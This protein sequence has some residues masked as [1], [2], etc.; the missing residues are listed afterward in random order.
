MPRVRV[1]LLAALLLVA[2]CTRPGE[3]PATTTK[4]GIEVVEPPADG[5]GPAPC[6]SRAAQRVAAPVEAKA[7]RDAG[8]RPPGIHLLDERTL[9]YVWAVYEDTLRDDRVTRIGDVTL[10]REPDGLMVVCVSLDIAAPQEVDT[11]RESYA[12][13]A[14]VRAPG[15]FTDGRMRVVVNWVA[16]CL[17]DP[18]PSGNATAQFD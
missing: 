16:G 17:C 2:G 12:V 6:A 9:L 15:G 14:E 1:L 5:G 11:T 10:D 7:T 4:P 8:G 18:L 13:A 3:G